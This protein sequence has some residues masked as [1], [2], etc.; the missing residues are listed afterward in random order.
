M[1]I[2]DDDDDESTGLSSTSR[3]DVNAAL[4]EQLIFFLG[5]GKTSCN[6]S[7]VRND[8]EVEMAVDEWL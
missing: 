2:H 8:G 1:N 3:T 7:F 4:V 6:S 5:G